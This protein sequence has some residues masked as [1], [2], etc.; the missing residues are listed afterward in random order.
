M[1]NKNYDLQN[2]INQLDAKSWNDVRMAIN[3]NKIKIDKAVYRNEE[4]KYG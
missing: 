4:A 2:T 1:K 3:N